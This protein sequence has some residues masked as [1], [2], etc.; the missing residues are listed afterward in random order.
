M[1][2][3]RSVLL[4]ITSAVIARLDRQSLCDA[5]F[6][7]I[8]GSMLPCNAVVLVLSNAETGSLETVMAEAETGSVRASGEEA[9]KNLGRLV[10]STGQGLALPS[11]DHRRLSEELLTWAGV[12]SCIAAPLITKGEPFGALIL[13][14]IA[15]GQNPEHDM[16]FLTRVCRQ[17]ALAVDNMLSYE[18]IA[19]LKSRL[20]RENAY[21]IDRKSV[22]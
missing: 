14:R 21:L 13:T 8:R 9:V 19:E 18:Q 15:R 1:L 3:Q 16:D 4:D 2:N 17:V 12:P 20:E 6:A 5:V 11:A 22:V 10:L 7:A